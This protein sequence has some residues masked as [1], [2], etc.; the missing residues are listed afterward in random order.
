MTKW[1]STSA[2]RVYLNVNNVA[3]SRYLAFSFQTVSLQLIKS[4]DGALCG[5]LCILIS[6]LFNNQL[7]FC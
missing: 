4:T 6:L 5:F 1:F 3:L 7:E 2:P